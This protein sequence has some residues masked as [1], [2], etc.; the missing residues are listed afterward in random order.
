MKDEKKFSDE[1]LSDEELE[2]VAGG[3]MQETTWDSH[4]LYDYGIISDYHN[5]PALLVHWESYSA[6]VDAG[7]SKVGITCVTEWSNHHNKYF[8]GDKEIS[9]D[10]AVKILKSKF[11]R[12]RYTFSH[13]DGIG[14]P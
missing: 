4:L 1:I 14:N 7:W 6:E 11:G 13:D 9:R 5:A 2:Q 8:A 3:D 12:I 10:E